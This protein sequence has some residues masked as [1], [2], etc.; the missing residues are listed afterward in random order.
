MSWWA[1]LRAGSGDAGQAGETVQ[2]K[3]PQDLAT[4]PYLEMNECDKFPS[5]QFWKNRD[6]FDRES[7]IIDLW[8]MCSKIRKKLS[9]KGLFI[10]SQ[11][12]MECLPYAWPC[13]LLQPIV[14]CSQG[15]EDKY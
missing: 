4:G 15:E 12:C 5:F 6:D 2:W 9:M 14:V 13:S 7:F 8:D 1:Q 11:I 10:H 3:N